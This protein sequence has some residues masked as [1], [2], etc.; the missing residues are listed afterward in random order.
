M[1][2][3][4]DFNCCNSSNCSLVDK[5]AFWFAAEFDDKAKFDNQARIKTIS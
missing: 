1:Y 2:L 4:P 3:N 5:A